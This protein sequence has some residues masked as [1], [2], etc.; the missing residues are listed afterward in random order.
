MSKESMEERYGVKGIKCTGKVNMNVVIFPYIP[1]MT[2]NCE[3]GVG[4]C[5]DKH[6][7]EI[8][9]MEEYTKRYDE[10]GY[11]C[12]MTKGYFEYKSKEEL[13]RILEDLK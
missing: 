5:Y 10:S 1:L 4:G 13:N 6:S 9:S 3:T 11:V 12:H 7:D 8:I 2:T